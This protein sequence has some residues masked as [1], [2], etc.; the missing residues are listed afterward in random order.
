MI[1]IDV[2]RQG[3][4]ILAMEIKNHA[5]Y[6][7]KGKDL[8]CA[9]VSCIVIGALNAIDQ[10]HEICGLEMK[11]ADVSIRVNKL[12]DHDTQVKLEMLRIQLITMQEAYPHYIQYHEQEV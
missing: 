4:M 10:N 2:K 11:E 6:A 3:K 9:G 1:R 5:G 8:V 7:E 12:T